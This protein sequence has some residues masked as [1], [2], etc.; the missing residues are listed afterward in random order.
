MRIGLMAG[1]T[2]ATGSTLDAMVDFAKM[3]EEKGFA[4]VW[5]ANI[6]G[7][8]AVSSLGIAGR[9]TSR[10]ELGT[11]VTP[12]YPRHPMALAQQALTSAVA[13]GGRFTLGIGL[14]HKVVIEDMMGLSY[15]GPAAHMEEY[16]QV[17]GPLLRGEPVSFQGEH[18]RVNGGL[19]VPDAPPVPLIIAALGPRM[20]EI[21]GRLADGTITWVTGPRALEDHIIPSINA[22]AEAAGK[23]APRIVCGLPV[24]VTSDVEGALEKVGKSL[25]VYSQL[26]SY[27]AMLDREGVADA[28]GVALIGS[29]QAIRQRLQHFRD[30]GVTDFNA[31]ITPTGE[32]VFED[33]LALLESE[34]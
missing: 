12:T 25:Q 31:A 9:E 29:E 24:A 19:T 18:Y 16:L 1:A 11:A 21:A 10:I 5:A 32:G 13:C 22:S 28:A 4:N 15:Q 34:L 33:T 30:I 23:P 26:P 3:A 20:L 14:S 2:E 8:D 6:F 17:L 27:R 7:I